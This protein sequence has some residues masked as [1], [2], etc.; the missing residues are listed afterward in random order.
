MKKKSDE[1]I[2]SLQK[3]RENVKE[4]IM[5]LLKEHK[6]KS[7][8]VQPYY[9]DYMIDNWSFFD[10]D[11]NGNGE[12]LECDRIKLVGKGVVLTMYTNYGDFFKTCTFADLDTNELL[13]VLHIVEDV[14]E[15]KVEEGTP[16]LKE[17]ETFDDYEDEK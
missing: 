3:I 4:E 12:C 2:N 17:N 8:N 15:L 11:K 14:I 6:I 16:I 7:I 10:T 9:Q 13:Y 5:R 1:F